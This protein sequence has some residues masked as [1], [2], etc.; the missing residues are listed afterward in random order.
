MTSTPAN[1]DGFK[2]GDIKI[3]GLYTPCHTQDSICWYMEDGDQKVVF[4]G[5]TLF[6]GGKFEHAFSDA[7]LLLA[8]SRLLRLWS[9]LRGHGY[10]DA[11]GS[12]QDAGCSAGRH[13]GLC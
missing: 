5:D 4:T 6:H 12:E 2:L 11:Q 8:H 9:V 3:K 13:H 10:R 1:G 7:R